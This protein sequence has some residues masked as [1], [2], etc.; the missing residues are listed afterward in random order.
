M[1]KDRGGEPNTGATPFYCGQEFS[2]V[3]FIPRK[4]FSLV[5]IIV[6]RA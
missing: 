4:A 2:R 5:Y 3:T 1:S 6:H